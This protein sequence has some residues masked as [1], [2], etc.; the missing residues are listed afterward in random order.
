MKINKDSLSAKAGNIAKERKISAN[1]VYSRYFFDCFLKRLSISPYV[2]KF[3][4]KGGLFLSS[5]LG[6]ENRSTLD[7][8]FVV[9]RIRM[10]RETIVKIIKEICQEKVD[11]NVSFEYVGDSEIMKDDIYGGFSVSVEGRLE[12]IRQK[13]DIDLATADVVYPSDREYE[14]KCL[15]T[16]EALRI[17]SYSIESF[18]SEK[19]QTF[20]LRGVLNSRAKDLYDLYVL[21]R[22]LTKDA[23]NLKE[24]F[25]ETCRSRDFE[26]DKEKAEKTLESV[27][28]SVM[29]RKLW[30]SYSR[31]TSYA[32]E[33]TFE[34][35][36]TS[37]GQLIEIMIE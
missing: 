18:V 7:I 13:F 15:I 33:I 27:S 32:K 35:V 11:D 16:G 26:T 22:F 24:A 36:I 25:M 1:V 23:V 2:E 6:I 31:K 28:A 14:Y 29:Q 4:L 19:L 12:N 9:R 8:D 10:E 3:V 20:L 30:E 17:K 34:D 37:I 21:E 5:V